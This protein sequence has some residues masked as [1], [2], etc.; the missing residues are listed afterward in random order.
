MKKYYVYPIILAAVATTSNF[1]GMYFMQIVAITIF[2][3]LI[4][5]TLL[6]WRFRLAF[7]LMGV[8]LML[9]LGLINT[10][11]LV[12]FAGLDIILFL[13]GMMIVIGYLEERHFFKHIIEKILTKTNNDAR[14]L[15]VI[16]MIMSAGLAA[17]VDEV[18]S[19]LFMVATVVHLTGKYRIGA[20]PLVIMTV[21]ATNIGSSATI[22]GNPIGIFI[23]L[24]GG[25]TFFEFLRWASPI[26]LVG[27]SITIPLCLWYFRN[28]I[29]KL[30]VAMKEKIKIQ[31]TEGELSVLQKQDHRLSWIIFIGTIAGLVA[32]SHLEKLLQLEPNVLLPGIAFAAA[33]TV[34]FLNREKAREL[35]E[36]RVDW[37]SLIFF[38]FLFA[39]VGALQALGITTLFAQN[40]VRVSGG[41]ETVLF[42]IFVPIVSLLSAFMDNVVAIAIF[43]PVVNYLGVLGM[44]N[45]P[46][47]WGMLFGGTFFG[48][49]TLIG[50]TAN[51]VAIGMIERRKG[52]Q[53]S[54]IEWLKPGLLVSVPTLLIAMLLIFLQIPLMPS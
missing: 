37:W 25:L 10:R 30:Q 46:L 29:G 20:I 4:A 47:W 1:L 26:S 38:V 52:A 48:N 23:A 39:S 53:I 32:H 51:I 49:L 44:N 35:V 3:G 9:G 14:K 28:Y 8:A 18:T 7:A 21:F 24:K 13:A 6:F 50:S 54:L 15:V 27:L 22:V 17:L 45:Y 12:E 34:L 11:I 19:I 42:F 41:D 2:S 36:K 31:T 43:T 40:L 5:G 33:G 16:L